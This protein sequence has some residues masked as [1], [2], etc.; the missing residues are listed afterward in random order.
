[1]YVYL[2]FLFCSGLFT[3]A[4][5]PRRLSTRPPGTPATTVDLGQCALR[6]EDWHL[7]L[8]DA[9]ATGVSPTPPAPALPVAATAVA[10]AGTIGGVAASMPPQVTVAALTGACGGG[11]LVSPLKSPLSALP[12]A[13]PTVRAPPDAR[14]VVVRGSTPP[15]AAEISAAPS[16]PTT[17]TTIRDAMASSL[18]SAAAATAALPSPDAVFYSPGRSPPPEPPPLPAGG[19]SGAGVWSSPPLV[20]DH[21]G[22]ALATVAVVAVEAAAVAASPAPTAMA[23]DDGFVAAP[24]KA[25]GKKKK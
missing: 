2:Y 19:D 9:I 16:V 17:A 18:G 14:I 15:P 13:A 11:P 6:D 25:K 8:T 5:H 7:L 23:D 12:S 22:S 20:M 21:F 24:V 10:A 4:A 1:M 3:Q